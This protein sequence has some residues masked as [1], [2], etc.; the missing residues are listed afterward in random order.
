MGSDKMSVAECK[1]VKGQKR[2]TLAEKGRI[3]TDELE[4]LYPNA[5]CS[6]NSKNP[7]ELIVATRL[8]A[9]CTDARVNLVTPSL[10]EKYPTP[11]SLASARQEDVEQCIKS[12]GLY[13]TKAKSLIEMSKTLC[14]KFDG[15]VPDNMKDLTSLPGIGRKT[16]NLI[17]GD[18]FGQPAVVADTHLIRI[19]NRLGLCDSRDPYK[20]EIKL[21]SVLDPHRSSDFCHRI[22][23]FGRDIC[24][25]RS[26]KCDKCPLIALCKSKGEF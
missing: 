18:V 4:K 5:I 2:P 6:L 25:A 10:F 11:K 26:P 7:F 20:V 12:C 24:T 17:L 13:K 23:L 21:K 14:E 8:S 3:C 15:Q 22:V 9:Q 19:S 16:A 1:T